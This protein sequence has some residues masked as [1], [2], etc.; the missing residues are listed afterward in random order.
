MGV[1]R[2]AARMSNLFNPYLPPTERGE[3][4]QCEL[5]VD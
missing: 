1:F 2:V 4:V 3:E 5:T